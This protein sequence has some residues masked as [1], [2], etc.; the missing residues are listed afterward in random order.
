MK[1]IEL[2]NILNSPCQSEHL[3]ADRDFDFIDVYIEDEQNM[4]SLVVLLKL[5]S[6]SVLKDG[7]FYKR[8][9]PLSLIL[10]LVLLYEKEYGSDF[11]TA[12]IAEKIIGYYNDI[13]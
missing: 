3:L 6:V 11:V 10:E 4:D 13:V 9:M 8:F 1:F 2:L 5:E 12:N 7:C